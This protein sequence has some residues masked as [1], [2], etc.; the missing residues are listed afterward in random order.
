MC[1]WVRKGTGLAALVMM[2]LAVPLVTRAEGGMTDPDETDSNVI[3]SIELE[4]TADIQEGSPCSAWDFEVNLLSP[5]CEVK[6]VELLNTNRVWGNADV[7]RLV[8]SLRSFDGAEFAIGESGLQIR[9]AECE[10]GH[11]DDFLNLY[12]LRL[13]LPSLRDQVGKIRDAYWTFPT[14]AAWSPASNAGYYEVLLYRG[15]ERQGNLFRVSAPSCDLGSRM[16]SEGVY[17][18]KVRGVQFRDE[19]VK[20]AWKESAPITVDGAAA[21]LNRQ[22]YLLSNG[23]ASASGG[24]AGSGTSAGSGDRYGWIAEGSL[25]WYRNPDNSY[26]INNWQLIDG[27][28]YYF[29]SMGYMVTGWIDW[30]GK[31]Y[32]C[33]PESGAMLVSRIVPDGRGLRVDSTGALIE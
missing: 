14:V 21:E 29:D 31:S 30:N 26:T 3:D 10:D 7:P 22:K 25:W 27:E 19:S 16:D 20:S 2:M 15:E 4:I 5:G 8:V 1:D 18:F 23:Q 24:A 9:G 6:E 17:S 11:Y 32:Y 12:I 28:W 13:R 33:D